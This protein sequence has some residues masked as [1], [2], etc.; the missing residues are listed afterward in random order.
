MIAIPVIADPRP[1]GLELFVFVERSSRIENSFQNNNIHSRSIDHTVANNRQS[2]NKPSKLQAPLLLKTSSEPDTKSVTVFVSSTSP[3]A[4][5][6]ATRL[7][8]STATPAA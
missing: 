8:I 3:A 4:A 1:T 2:F 7:L 6:S 5:R